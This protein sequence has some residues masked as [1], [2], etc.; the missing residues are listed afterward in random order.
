MVLLNGTLG[1]TIAFLIEKFTT[2][3]KVLISIVSCILVV[4]A[5]A[6]L[7]FSDR[8]CLYSYVKAPSAQINR[9]E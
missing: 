8:T 7:Q 5:F 1:A 4:G 6:G 2:S 3:K 9:G